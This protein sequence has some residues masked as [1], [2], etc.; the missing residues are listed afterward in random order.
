M[1]TQAIAELLQRTMGLTASTIGA[2]VVERAI[3]SRMVRAGSG[4]AEAYLARLQADRAELDELIEEVVVP[5][6]WFFRDGTPFATLK[7]WVLEQ[8][9]PA[10]PFET[11]RVLTVPCSTGEEPY[12]VA[13]ALLDAGLA[14][15]RFSV[16]GI[17]ISR[18]ALARAQEGNYRA[19]S[20]RG[21]DLEFRDRYF[22][23]T[24][25][26]EYTIAANVRQVV[27]LEQGN[28]LAPGFLMQSSVRYDVIFCRNLLIYFDRPTQAKAARTL[29]NLLGRDGVLFVGHAETAALGGSGFVPTDHAMSFC[30]RKVQ[31]AAGGT[32][33][34]TP[35][36]WRTARMLPVSPMTQTAQPTLTPAPAP[37]PA[38]RSFQPPVPPSTKPVQLAT[39]A[40]RVTTRMP[41]P[42]PA[43][44]RK[45]LRVGFKG[46]TG[47]VPGGGKGDGLEEARKLADAGK[48]REAARLCETHLRDR[49][50]TAA[51]WYLLGLVRDASGDRTRAAECYTKTLYLDPCHH[52]ALLQRALI[53]ESTGDAATAA[54]L[55]GRAQRAGER[56]GEP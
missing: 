45:T 43:A 38:T 18:R 16:H 13:M 40:P 23:A 2:S 6:S 56:Q 17:D 47:H 37:A 51:A 55:R 28:I 35:R 9:L 14:P 24:A 11:L 22:Q 21:K 3:L 44:P 26:G 46:G 29:A 52:E 31:T 33:F 50:A 27:R 8:W 39:R 41:P 12:S 5:E 25:D 20:F 7:R 19:H 54:R 1:S 4:S 15:G 42:P 30:F 32:P 10:H 34:V 36:V 49:G 48:L 53:A